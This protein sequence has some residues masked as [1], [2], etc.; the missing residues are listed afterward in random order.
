VGTRR[1]RAGCSEEVDGD[2]HEHDE[3]GEL[4]GQRRTEPRVRAIEMIRR[5][6]SYMG[7]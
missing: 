1:A 6:A 5:G 4:G 2:R 3:H 7:V